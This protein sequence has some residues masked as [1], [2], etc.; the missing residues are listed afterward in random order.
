MHQYSLK[1]ILQV[2]CLIVLMIGVTGLANAQVAMGVRAG[3]SV[4]PEQGYLGGHI[5]TASF[6]SDIRFRP[7]VEVG[8]GDN[9]T[10]VGLNGEF[11]YRLQNNSSGVYF[12]AGPAINFINIDHPL[13]DDNRTDAGFNFM[14]GAELSR[15]W[16]AEVKMGA[17]ESPRLKIGI[18]YIF[19]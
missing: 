5:E 12:G 4:D 15:N 17:F 8:F 14:V 13:G 9:R 6:V 18:G 3:V 19:P 2:L 7:N 16:F 10:I 1:W 11:I